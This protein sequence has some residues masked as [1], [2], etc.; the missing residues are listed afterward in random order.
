MKDRDINL[1]RRQQQ[2]LPLTDTCSETNGKDGEAEAP[3]LQD[4]IQI[5]NK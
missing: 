5:L 1:M 4:K 3:L 2:R